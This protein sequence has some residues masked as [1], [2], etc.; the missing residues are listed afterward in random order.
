M[1]L[2]VYI[3]CLVFGGIFI[4]ASLV[5]GHHGDGQ[6]GHDG[7]DGHGHEGHHG[8]HTSLLPFLS[9]R[10]WTF[11]LGFFGL[12]GAVLTATGALPLALVPVVAGGVGLSSGYGAARLLGS[13]ARRPVGLV[14]SS[15]SHVGREGKLLLPVDKGQRGKVRLEIGGVSTDLIAE[16]DAAEALSA[17]TIVLVVGMRDAVAVVERSPAALPPLSPE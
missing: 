14:A 16:T 13:L 10:F 11:S 17:G 2:S 1:A 6:G 8:P 4:G 9:L 5:G 12:A 15:A 7:H 3:A